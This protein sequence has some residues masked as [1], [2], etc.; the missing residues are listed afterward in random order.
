MA[1]PDHVN[2]NVWECH[3]VL[4]LCEAPQVPLVPLH[5][6]RLGT[7][8][9]GGCEEQIPGSCED[10]EAGLLP[11]DWLHGQRQRWGQWMVWGWLETCMTKECR[12][13]SH[14]VYQVLIK[15]VRTLVRKPRCLGKVSN[16]CFLRHE[17]QTMT[18]FGTQYSTQGPG[19]DE[20]L[21]TDRAHRG[22]SP[23]RGSQPGLTTARWLMVVTISSSVTEVPPVPRLPCFVRLWETRRWK[24]PVREWWSG[25]SDVCWA[26]KQTWTWNCAVIPRHFL[27]PQKKLIE[28]RRRSFFQCNCQK[29]S[30]YKMLFSLYK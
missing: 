15:A 21:L 10:I 3:Q 13:R 14:A 27:C 30:S 17:P 19:V 24:S 12:F 11:V 9:L 29:K 8:A 5:Q 7:D 2:W 6:P 4:V 22:R 28:C 26:N 20:C 18:V 25:P 1:S 23:P 16:N